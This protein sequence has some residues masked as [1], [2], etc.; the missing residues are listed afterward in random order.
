MHD[1]VIGSGI[2]GVAM[3]HAPGRAGINVDQFENHVLK[4]AID[5]RQC[6]I[7]RLR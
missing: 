7:V 6:S 4:S 1:A 5:D 3:A 2:A